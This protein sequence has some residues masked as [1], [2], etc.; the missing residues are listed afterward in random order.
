MSNRAKI[1]EDAM[2]MN[3]IDDAFFMKMAEDIAFCEEIIQTIL[4]DKS[5]KAISCT[6]QYVAK[7][8]QGRSCILDLKCILGD[9]KLV[10]VEVQRADDDDHQKRVMYNAALLATNN[11]N[12]NIKFEYILDIIV[13]FISAFDIFGYGDVLYHID[14]KVRHHKMIVHNGI[15]E[16]YVNATAR[17]KSD[18]SALMRIFTEDNAYD[19]SK[20][21]YTSSR[22]RRFKTTEEGV[23]EMCEIIERNRREAKAE[24]KAEA[25]IEMLKDNLSVAKIAQYTKLTVEQITAIGKKAALL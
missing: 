10:N 22:K 19:D 14:R 15:Q 25:V 1:R 16:V 7:N 4:E 23:S 9:G 2:R 17:D 18:I 8:M 5:I 13:I 20:F 21:P 24:G 6:P 12:P 3:P 11:I